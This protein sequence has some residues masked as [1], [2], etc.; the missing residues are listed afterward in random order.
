MG[1]AVKKMKNQDIA[2]RVLK[3]VVDKKLDMSQMFKYAY[4]DRF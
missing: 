4:V 3:A 1:K 2:T